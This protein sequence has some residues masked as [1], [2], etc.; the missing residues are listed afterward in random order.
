MDCPASHVTLRGQLLYVIRYWKVQVPQKKSK[1]FQWLKIP[2]ARSCLV[3]GILWGKTWK[4]MDPDGFFCE[5]KDCH[6][7]E[8]VT[9]N[10]HIPRTTW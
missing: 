10:G 1:D 9:E 3:A 5:I 6:G 7:C 8:M 2:P 4:T